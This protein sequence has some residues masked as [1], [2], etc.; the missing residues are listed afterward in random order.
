MKKEYTKFF[1]KGDFVVHVAMPSSTAISIVT[2]HTK[3][4]LI[5]LKY[6]L[7][8]IKW[9]IFRCSNNAHFYLHANNLFLNFEI[10]LFYVHI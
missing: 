7:L 2:L 10:A 1:G 3:L 8:P 9:N 6:N 5:L 4:G